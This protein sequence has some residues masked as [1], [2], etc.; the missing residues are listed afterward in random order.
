MPTPA[1]PRAASRACAQP[2][3]WY[4]P[5]LSPVESFVRS[6]MGGMRDDLSRDP[7]RAP[8][9]GLGGAVVANV[10]RGFGTRRWQEASRVA[11]LA[12]ESYNQRVQLGS[13]TLAARN[14]WLARDVTRIRRVWRGLVRRDE[15]LVARVVARIIGAP[16]DLGDDAVPECVLFLRVAVAAGVLAGG[17]PDSVHAALD[18]YFTCL[19]LAWESTQGTLTADGWRGALHAVGLDGDVA[20]P[21]DPAER[22]REGA[23]RALADLPDGLPAERLERLLACVPDDPGRGRDPVAYDPQLA[24]IARAH[25]PRSATGDSA[26]DRFAALW[27][28]PIEGALAELAR[29]ESRVLGRALLYLQHQGGKRVRPLVV[30]GAATACGADAGDALR[31]AALVE[32]LHQASLV[33]DD[34]V[35]ESKLRRN[36]P[37]LHHATSV[38]FA[39]G[40]A[41]YLLARIHTSLR[42]LPPPVRDQ[43]ADAATSLIE[44]QRAE[45]VH[46]GDLALGSTGYYRIIEAKTARLFVCAAAVGGLCAG[47]S[48]PVVRAL[49]TF[50]REA[51]LAFQ[52]VDDV[53]D[54]AGDERELGKR[55]GTDLRARKATLPLL[56][57]RDRLGARERTWLAA[58]LASEPSSAQEEA[59]AL[60][61]SQQAMGA[62]GVYD[63]CFDRARLHLERASAAV[64]PLPSASAASLLSEL[65]RRFV[66]RRA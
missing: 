10:A 41:G 45:L 43:I 65:A 31:A 66:E 16:P 12:V 52:I 42:T 3:R 18:R 40:V 2:I 13:P 21:R 50:G 4:A 46:T 47:A 15:D 6:A 53:L 48:P 49:R 37:T 26:L 5:L 8:R 62:L 39:V 33:L 56:V 38:P 36:G 20:L 7:W 22:A 19:G 35:D 60:E 44:G 63:A 14:A 23:R 55:P 30:L 61:W 9:A 17:V 57:L 1:Q 59:R 11:I 24:P 25:A 34:V 58:L 64:V 28:D 54:Y 32:W 29:S 51:G 27:A